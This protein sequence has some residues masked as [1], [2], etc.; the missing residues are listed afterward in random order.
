MRPIVRIIFALF[1]VAAFQSAAQAHPHVWVKGNT[2][3]NFEAGKIASIT[4]DWVFDE[5][6]SAFAVEGLTKPGALVTREQFDAL[7]K[8]NAGSLAELGYFTTLK[9]NGKPVAFGQAR[10]YYMEEL[11]S[12]LVHFHVTLPLQT[13]QNT[14]RAAILQVYDPTYFID[15]EFDDGKAPG[16]NLNGYDPNDNGEPTPAQIEALNVKQ[17]A[18]IHMVGAPEGCSLTVLTPEPLTLADSKKLSE[19]FFTGLSPGQDFG[20]KLAPRAIIVCP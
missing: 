6:Y 16:S 20:I 17:K 1:M 18:A 14:G 13:P 7:A 4:Q 15:F 5:S 3:L 11:A 2:T 10:D 8:E 9:I 19:S 12:H